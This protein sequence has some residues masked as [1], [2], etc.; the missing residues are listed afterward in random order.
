M[1]TEHVP[2]R[3]GLRL[4]PAQPGPS[5]HQ[6]A[7]PD[8]RRTAESRHPSVHTS[9]SVNHAHSEPMKA[10]APATTTYYCP[11]F[12]P[13]TAALQK[14]TLAPLCAHNLRASHSPCSSAQCSIPYPRI[15][16]PHSNT[17]NHKQTTNVKC[18]KP[19]P[20]RSSPPRIGS[21]PLQAPPESSLPPHDRYNWQCTAGSRHPSVHTMTHVNHIHR[22]HQGVCTPCNHHSSPPNSSSQ[23]SQ[24]G[25]HTHPRIPLCAQRQPALLS[26]TRR[27]AL[28]SLFLA[29]LRTHKQAAN[30]KWA[31]MP[32]HVPTTT[33]WLGSQPLPAPPEHSLSEHARSHWQRTVG[34]RHSS[35][36]TI[37]HVNNKKPADEGSSFSKSYHQNP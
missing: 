20:R 17:N 10:L 11:P 13:N 14:H 12:V 28:Q 23:T 21:Q 29:T 30:V 26:D 19:K 16:A 3:L 22:T 34:S 25:R 15:V 27:T 35:V 33:P 37:K 1:K 5:L 36:H 32:S 6:H 31:P 8:W 18:T 2:P 7:P 24:R 4:L 9:I